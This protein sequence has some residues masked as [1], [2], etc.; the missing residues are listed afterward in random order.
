MESM[1][2][3]QNSFL[4]LTFD[5]KY[6]E[7]KGRFNVDRKELTNYIR[8]IRREF[9]K[10][11]RV[12]AIGEYGDESYRPHYHLALFGIGPHSHKTLDDYW[13][14][15]ITHVGEVN[16]FSA[17]YICGYYASKVT[18]R[19]DPNMRLFEDEFKY[20]SKQEGGI[21]APAVS[22]IA[23]KLKTG[24][25][26]KGQRIRELYV[27]KKAYPLGRY[28]IKKFDKELGIDHDD[29]DC[30]NQACMQEIFNQY[31]ADNF[32]VQFLKE[33]DQ[34]VKQQEKRYRI[35]KQRNKI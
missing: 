2:H 8:R 18:K 7:E 34:R 27:G 16:S 26:W 29:I 4:T 14:K 3:K 17:R 22:I 33:N 32:K 12:Y 35:F 11:V 31:S 13:G 1:C 30:D 24:G 20:M 9:G 23:E 28:L 5:K 6:L 19:D 10:G 15:G 25:H 21:G